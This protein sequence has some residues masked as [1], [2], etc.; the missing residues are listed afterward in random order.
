[1]MYSMT[2]NTNITKKVFNSHITQFLSTHVNV[3]KFAV[4]TIYHVCSWT[5]IY[6]YC[7]TNHTLLLQH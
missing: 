6:Y 3:K 2:Q 4:L 1:M 5:N 7:T